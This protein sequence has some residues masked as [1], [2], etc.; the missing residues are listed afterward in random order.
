MAY[1]SSLSRPLD[2]R[3]GRA[4]RVSRNTRPSEVSIQFAV[5]RNFTVTRP[6]DSIWRRED[7]A[8]QGKRRTV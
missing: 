1:R 6:S 2:R 4:I 7:E 3:C 5:Q 8:I